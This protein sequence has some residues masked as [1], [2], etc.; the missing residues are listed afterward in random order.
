V[1]VGSIKGG[2]GLVNAA[3]PILNWIYHWI[4]R[5]HLS[6]K[7]S[8]LELILLVSKVGLD[9]GVRVIDD[10][11][12]HVEQDEEDEEDVEAEERRS[13]DA[14][15]LLQGLEVEVSEDQTEQRETDRTNNSHTLE[16]LSSK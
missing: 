16:I 5:T 15:R 3:V 6:E 11:E 7:V 2:R 1:G 13:E 12:E 10:G 4:N 14:V 9:V 8:H